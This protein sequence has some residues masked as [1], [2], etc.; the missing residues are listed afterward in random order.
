MGL[1]EGRHRAAKLVKSLHQDLLLSEYSQ[2]RRTLG[3]KFC[4][5]GISFVVK[6]L[7]TMRLTGVTFTY[8]LGGEQEMTGGKSST[9]VPVCSHWGCLSE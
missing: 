7:L 3:H 5:L 6:L 4:L 9:R 2:W 1:P 8:R